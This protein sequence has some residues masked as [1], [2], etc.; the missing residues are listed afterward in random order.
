MVPYKLHTLKIPRNTLKIPHFSAIN[1]LTSLFRLLIMQTSILQKINNRTNMFYCESRFLNDLP[2]LKGRL[3][4]LWAG[5]DQFYHL[6]LCSVLR[7]SYSK[8]GENIHHTCRELS[9]EQDVRYFSTGLI[10]ARSLTAQ[11]I[12]TINPEKGI[13]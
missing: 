6:K 5:I 8:G 2:H 4:E 11:G 3:T 9:R 1:L 13:H 12:S 7:T 10:N